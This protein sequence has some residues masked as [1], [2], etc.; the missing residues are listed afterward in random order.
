MRGR[1]C[2]RARAR[3]CA[4][5]CVNVRK[6]GKNCSWLHVIENRPARIRRDN[7]CRNR[8]SVSQ[9]LLGV[10]KKENEKHVKEKIR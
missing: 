1:V 6:L 3:L 5:M 9:P 2:A 8:P 7:E 4:C 10:M